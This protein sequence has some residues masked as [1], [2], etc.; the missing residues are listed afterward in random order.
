MCA[1]ACS[2]MS[3]G[4]KV[5]GVMGPLG[6]KQ[7]LITHTS[8]SMKPFEAQPNGLHVASS[9]KRDLS[10]VSLMFGLL[11]SAADLHFIL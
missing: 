11:V 2:L 9:I 4:V 10:A 3:Q 8:T 1:A 6:V 7:T 5:S